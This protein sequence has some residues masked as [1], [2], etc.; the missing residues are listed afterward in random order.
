MR[1]F[2]VIALAVLLG[3]CRQKDS[4]K[5]NFYASLP[6]YSCRGQ[7]E[8]KQLTFDTLEFDGSRSSMEGQFFIKGDSVYMADEVV[9]AILS[10]DKD[11]RYA[12]QSVRRGNGP[13]EILGITG[14]ASRGEGCISV[15]GNWIVSVFDRDW[16][17]IYNFRIDWVPKHTIAEQRKSPDPEDSGI[18]EMEF[19][20]RLIRPYGENKMLLYITSEHPD[21]NAF[22]EG[23]AEK[24]YRESY[25][26]ALI[27]LDS[28][29]VEK[30]LCP[31]PSLYSRYHFLSTFKNQ[32]FD[33]H[34]KSL[35]YSFE[36]DSLIYHYVP[37]MSTCI[38]FGCAGRGMNTTYPVY[39]HVDDF[40]KNYAKDREKY[41]YYRY[42]K[43]DDVHKFLFRGYRRGETS[44]SDGL[45]IY[46]DDCLIADVD[47]PR[48]F[49]LVGYIKPY[50]YA[51]GGSN[52]GKEIMTFYRFKL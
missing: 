50:F 13:N 41:G 25:T 4:Q 44:L 22:N 26:I 46:R 49:E 16:K 2:I 29:R 36:A 14:I 39:T 52:Y 6:I 48:G 51:Y 24:F 21:F 3:A 20:K 32:L 10:F 17:R 34:G 18:Y 45:Q 23:A 11:G 27:S 47:V 37:E 43:Y 9:G 40:D 1:I 28:G 31:Y 7:E 8:V 19:Y 38:S 33:T 15:D 12:G 5:E 30:L 35:F 42:L